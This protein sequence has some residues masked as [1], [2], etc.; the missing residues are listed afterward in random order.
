M[1]EALIEEA[2]R[3]LELQLLGKQVIVPIP[4]PGEREVRRRRRAGLPDTMEEDIP[5]TEIH[6]GKHETLESIIAEQI[7]KREEREMRDLKGKGKAWEVTTEKKMWK[8][9]KR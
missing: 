5:L 3:I 7:Q 6:L 8:V 2:Y 1:E 9:A 4:L